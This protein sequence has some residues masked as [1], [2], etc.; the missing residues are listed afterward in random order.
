MS[1]GVAP[2]PA[3]PEHPNDFGGTGERMSSEP[4]PECPKSTDRMKGSGYDGHD[5]QDPAPP[6]NDVE[7]SN[8][9]GKTGCISTT[10][11]TDSGVFTTSCTSDTQEIMTFDHHDTVA[12]AGAIL[13]VSGNGEMDKSTASV[14]TIS[15][16]HAAVTN[17]CSK[18]PKKNG[19]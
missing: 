8:T 10:G 2:M 16:G 11:W 18:I 1:G 4:P 17:G 19:V 12:A 5:P 15:P 9:G 7:S 3:T 13:G 14:D 6:F